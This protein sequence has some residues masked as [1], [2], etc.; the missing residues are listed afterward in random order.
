MVSRDDAAHGRDHGRVSSLPSA[1][2]LARWCGALAVLVVL[3]AVAGRWSNRAVPDTE[4]VGAFWTLPVVGGLAYAAFGG[5]LATVRPR[6]PLGWLML[7]VGW[8]MAL[9]SIGQEYAV[10]AVDRHPGWPAESAVL[11]VASWLWLPAYL[12]VGLVLPLTLP[13]GHL[14]TRSHRPLLV[15]AGLATLLAGARIAVTPYADQDPPITL[16]NLENPL[17]AGWWDNPLLAVVSTVLVVGCLLTGLGVLVWRWRRATSDRAALSTTMLGLLVTVALAVAAFLVPNAWVPYVLGLAPAPLP[18]A[19]LVAVLRH[20]LGDVEVVLSKVLGYALLSGVVACAYV[21]LVGVLGGAL[22]Q[23]TGAPVLVTAVLAVL[24]LPLHRR[25]QAGVNRVVHGNSRD[26][27]AVLAEL[28]ERLEGVERSQAVVDRMLPALLDSLA[29]AVRRPVALCLTDGTV[30]GDPAEQAEPQAVDLVYAGET[31]GQ[32]LVDVGPGPL[33]RGETRVVDQVARQVAVAAHTVQLDRALSRSQQ[34]LVR[35]RE[36]ER[37][38]LRHDLHDGVG[39]VLAA[40]ALQV[41]TARATYRADPE[42]AGAMLDTAADQLAVAVDD[43]RQVVRGLRPVGLDDLGLA[44][45]LEVLAQRFSGAGTAVTTTIGELP[46]RSAAVDS[47]CYLVAA[48]AVAN[49]VRHARPRTVRVE[50]GPVSGG[51]ALTV[52]DD[53]GGFTAPAGA[54][55]GSGGTGL[56][57]MRERVEQ[58]AGRFDVRSGAGGTTVSAWLPGGA[59]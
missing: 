32:L 42:A 7:G 10:A 25:V 39:P 29:S 45:A 55:N 5:W 54:P 34:E 16:G 6:L 56:R 12:L 33:S 1:S 51:L 19:C 30:V 28:G 4:F 59:G 37:R 11:W 52:I 44:S 3:V 13:T 23:G 18:L 17:A 38:R 27:F 35:A 47:A 22:G 2:R 26:P 20:G 40:A 14:A 8:L 57:S 43:V 50:L 9:A 24:V 15:L 46:P 48:E 21:A 31:Q 41:E 36:E 53:G 49:A 58:L